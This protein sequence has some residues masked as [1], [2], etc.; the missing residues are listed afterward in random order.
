[1]R[2]PLRLVGG[3]C[4][5]MIVA[6][7]RGGVVPVDLS[8]YFNSPLK[9]GYPTGEQTLGGVPFLLGTEESWMWHAHQAG[10]ENPRVLEI[11]LDH[12]PAVGAYT[13]MNTY[14]GQ[15]G[16]ASYV[17][18][19]FLGSAGAEATFELVGNVHIRDFLQNF[20]T[21]SITS[22]DTV[23]V[24][25]ANTPEGSVRL[26]RQYFELPPE[27][28]GQDLAGVVVSDTGAN[29]FQRAF[30]VGLT[31]VTPSC[32]ADRDGDGE[33]T[34]SDLLAYLGAFRGGD[35]DVTGDGQTDVSDLLAYLGAFR[36]GC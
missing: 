29:L 27:F 2:Y 24:F 3:V 7:A 12:G 25:A 17:S 34:V 30:L 15:P 4:A 14:W 11:S 6:G 28:A 33:A 36:A 32:S 16:P 26:D 19:T 9:V 31:L 13:L 20:W 5:G 21:N 23:Q 35:A 22:P 10:G 8:A 1:M 18:V